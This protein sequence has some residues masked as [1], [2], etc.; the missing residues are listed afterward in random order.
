MAPIAC[1][2]SGERRASLHDRR[3]RLR[4]FVHAA[5]APGVQIREGEPATRASVLTCRPHRA[6]RIAVD[7]S[8]VAGGTAPVAFVQSGHVRMVGDRGLAAA[9]V[10]ASGCRSSPSPADER[11]KG[12]AISPAAIVPLRSVFSW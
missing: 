7:H 5:A 10:P 2:P 4:Q 9:T 1:I 6:R 3:G 8:T 11:F 12:M